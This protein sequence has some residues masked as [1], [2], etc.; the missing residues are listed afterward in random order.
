[1]TKIDNLKKV[2]LRLEAGT[3]ADDMN[4]SLT[5]SE[6]E[7]IFGVGPG[8]M[9]PFEYHLVNKA[10]GEEI[11]MP[12]KKEE[13]QRMFEHLHLPI[14]SLFEKHELLHLKIH[15][16]KIEQADSRAVVKALADMTSHDHG[17][18]CG[19]GC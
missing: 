19:C 1:M 17:C 14:M 7:F 18:D 5:S 10:A 2:T 16:L 8:G 12:L 6:F 15:I 9:C 3:T 11:S 4:L 13:T